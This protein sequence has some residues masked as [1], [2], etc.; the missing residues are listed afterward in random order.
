MKNNLLIFDFFCGSG[1]LSSE[2]NSILT[3]DYP[4]L[5]RR[6][7]LP[8]YHHGYIFNFNFNL[9][10]EKWPCHNQNLFEKFISQLEQER[11]QKP[12]ASNRFVCLECI[13]DYLLMNSDIDER[14]IA[15]AKQNTMN[16]FK[17]GKLGTKEEVT[18]P[19]VLFVLALDF[20]TFLFLKP[21]S[22]SVRSS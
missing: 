12:M 20:S 13:E 5:Q 21:T 17:L 16:L 22:S 15:C 10:F 14:A 11:N 7:L 18:L 2:F 19:D 6:R 8:D 4:Y 9:R 1:V 3:H